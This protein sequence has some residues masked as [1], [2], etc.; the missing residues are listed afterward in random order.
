MGRFNIVKM[1]N[2]PKLI[3]KYGGTP[4]EISVDVEVKLDDLVIK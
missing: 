4:S 1:S 3:Q 2:F